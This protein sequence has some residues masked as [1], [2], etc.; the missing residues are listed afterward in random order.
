MASILIVQSKGAVRAL[1][2]EI[3]E[4]AGHLVSE[5]AEG[6]KGLRSLDEWAMDVV[7]TDIHLSDCD[8][9]QVIGSLRR[10]FPAVNIVAVSALAGYEESLVTAT[11][12]GADAVLQDALD[13]EALVEAVN[14]LVGRS[15]RTER[16]Q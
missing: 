14:R 8:G 9:L 12:R 16:A 3:L 11:L 13:G 6:L 4:R 15:R 10:K 5:S 2:R 7:I 1:Y